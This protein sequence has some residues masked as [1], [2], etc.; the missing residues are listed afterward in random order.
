MTM[1][2]SL[3]WFGS[4]KDPSLQHEFL[5]Y[6][7]KQRSKF[8]FGIT[9]VLILGWSVLE[10]IVSIWLTDD[11]HGSEKVVNDIYGIISLVCTGIAFLL[12]AIVC[13]SLFKMKNPLIYSYLQVSLIF[14]VNLLFL[15]KMGKVAQLGLPQCIPYDSKKYI[16]SSSFFSSNSTVVLP[17]FC[18]SSH[19]YKSISKFSSVLG[20]VFSFE[21]WTVICLEPRVYVVWTC[22]FLITAFMVNSIYNSF[23]SM[24]PLT[25]Y[26]LTAALLFGEVHFQRIRSFLDQKKIQELLEENERNADANHAM[27]M[28]HMIGNVAHDL[29]TVSFLF[30]LLL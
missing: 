3:N 19:S 5:L 11:Y 6:C 23:F 2:T 18:P 14:M 26:L 10:S 8:T 4:F 21:L 29:K 20:M 16:I 15:L 7:M 28:R 24:I 22:H 13:F 17:P 30:L 9:T 25:T 1:F 27:E 12:W